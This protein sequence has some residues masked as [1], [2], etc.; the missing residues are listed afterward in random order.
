MSLSKR[1][2]VRPALFSLAETPKS[3]PNIYK[4]D[5][6]ALVLDKELGAT[7]YPCA[8]YVGCCM[9]ASSFVG[10]GGSSCT[11]EDNDQLRI[12]QHNHKHA[13]LRNMH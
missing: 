1:W 2:H 5:R 4:L 7:S 6:L 9:A 13:T 12:D 11:D 3:G 10:G 8:S